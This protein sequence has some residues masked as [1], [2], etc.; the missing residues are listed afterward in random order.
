MKKSLGKRLKKPTATRTFT[1][2]RGIVVSS[3]ERFSA[4]R[5]SSYLTRV[6]YY[7]EREALFRKVPITWGPHGF[8]LL[9]FAAQFAHGPSNVGK[10]S[11][12]RLTLGLT[13]K[14]FFSIFIRF[15]GTGISDYRVGF[16]T[17]ASGRNSAFMRHFIFVNNLDWN[18][19]FRRV[20]HVV[21]PSF[22]PRFSIY[23]SN[24][25]SWP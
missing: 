5:E 15:N 4:Y 1:E 21:G 7:L 10:F 23:I 24:F 2:W 16:D 6:Q 19:D 13:Q 17:V 3:R 18:H 12:W 25:L 14:Q 8:P 22:T 11:T 20:W 9:M